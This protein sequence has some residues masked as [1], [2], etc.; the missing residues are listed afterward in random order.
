MKELPED[1]CIDELLKSVRRDEPT[2]EAIGGIGEEVVRADGSRALKV[3]R[4]K[5]RSEQPKKKKELRDKK[6]KLFLIAACFCSVFLLI[7]A[8]VF[9]IAYHNSKTF[10]EKVRVSVAAE[11]GADVKL[12][13]IKLSPWSATGKSIE[14]D[15]PA[16]KGMLRSLE[17]EGLTASYGLGGFF[18]GEWTSSSVNSATGKLT[19]RDSVTPALV[20]M[21]QSTIDFDINGFGCNKLDIYWE[22]QNRIWLEDAAVTYKSNDDGDQKFIISGGKFGRGVLAAFPIN[23]GV[24]RFEEEG[25]DLSVRLEDENNRSAVSVRGSMPYGSAA[26]GQFET[27]YESFPVNVLLGEVV[28]RLFNGA[29]DSE[30]GALTLV[31]GKPEAIKFQL[32]ATS[33]DFQISGFQFLSN[34]SEAF[35]KEWYER[36][37]FSDL[38]SLKVT[39]DGG[40]ITLSELHLENSMMLKITGE[41]TFHEDGK[42][43][44]AL[45]VG[46]PLKSRKTLKTELS[47]GLFKKVRSNYAWETVN[48][49]GTVHE[50]SDDFQQRLDKVSESAKNGG[51]SEKIE[52]V[53]PSGLDLSPKVSPGARFDQH[54]NE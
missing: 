30:K 40:T 45:E 50:P 35:R 10:H 38:V 23:N 53:K 9:S 27:N 52:Q 36:P 34:L 39:R 1:D 11:S 22:G 2:T 25:I 49:S 47:K 28:G 24:L 16:G 17:L 5:R 20:S 33:T 42:L 8:V 12:G 21:G 19:L 7:L 6:R 44:G 14:L 31:R 3:R 13:S 54:L 32:S 37:L 15:W 51:E 4:R 41:M 18:G 29:I 48:L 43:T 26:S 46:V